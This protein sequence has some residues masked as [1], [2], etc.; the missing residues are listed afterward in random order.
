MTPSVF[1][2]QVYDINRTDFY[3]TEQLHY[4]HVPF[5]CWLCLIYGNKPHPAVAPQVPLT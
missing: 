3:L 1:A 4:S 5:K 2:Q